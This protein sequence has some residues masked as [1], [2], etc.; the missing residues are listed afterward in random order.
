MWLPTHQKY[1][2]EHFEKW[3]F[4]TIGEDE[5]G[6]KSQALY[7]LSSSPRSSL[8]FLE[9]TLFVLH[10][11]NTSALKSLLH[12]KLF[13]FYWGMKIA[14]SGQNNHAGIDQ[15]LLFLLFVCCCQ[16]KQNCDQ[17][18]DARGEGRRRKQRSLEICHQI[19]R[20]SYFH[21]KTFQSWL[22][23]SHSPTLAGPRS[24]ARG[25]RDSGDSET[26]CW[27]R[28]CPER[29]PDSHLLLRAPKWKCCQSIL[30]IHQSASTKTTHQSSQQDMDWEGL[31]IRG[32]RWHLW[33]HYLPSTRLQ[34][35]G[36]FQTDR[37]A[38]GP[39]ERPLVEEHS[40]YIIE[41]LTHLFLAWLNKYSYRN[42]EQK[43]KSVIKHQKNR[44]W[45][46]FLTSNNAPPLPCMLWGPTML[47]AWWAGYSTRG[48]AM[49]SCSMTP[50][51]SRWTSSSD[52][53]SAVRGVRAAT[54]PSC[55]PR[56]RPRKP[57][58]TAEPNSVICGAKRH[59]R[60]QTHLS[61]L[62]KMVIYIVGY[63]YRINNGRVFVLFALILTST[64]HR[65]L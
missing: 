43:Y 37:G 17:N 44:H 52:T 21:S 40:N 2:G 61:T 1:G 38:A 27:T 23:A 8:Q 46:L 11:K 62:Y 60:Q 59:E 12:T 19:F 4:G 6:K 56:R 3:G 31:G 42:A 34:S 15:C 63:L 13:S 36:C 49:P 32:R 51:R 35:W 33:E 18:P 26:V 10:R 47:V 16:K 9:Q 58:R 48:R 53:W 65:A 45:C 5:G 14:S 41:A 54:L 50:C 22:E 39:R 30:N 28:L 57:N 20:C 64:Q 7:P 55:K 25:R 24:R 29:F